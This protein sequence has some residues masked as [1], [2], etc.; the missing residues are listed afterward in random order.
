MLQKSIIR[1]FLILSLLSGIMM[2]IIFPFY[3]NIFIASW[4]S[5]TMMFIFIGGC[6][7]AGIVV[8]LM[9][10][11]IFKYTIFTVL[12]KLSD[13]LKKIAEEDGNLKTRIN[14]QSN[15]EIGALADNFNIFISKIQN[16]VDDVQKTLLTISDFSE[17]L[18][19]T[20]S[21]FSENSISQASSAEEATASAEE[22]LANAEETAKHT[23]EQFDKL[24]LLI[25]RMTELTEIIE[26]AGETVDN[27]L[28]VSQSLATTADQGTGYLEN[29]RSSMEKINYSSE[30]VTSIV[31]IINDISDQINLLSLNAAIEAA[32]AG[33]AGRGFAVVADEISKLADQTS[34]SAKEINILIKDNNDEINRGYETSENT[35][36]VIHQITDGVKNISLMMD[37]IHSNIE[38]EVEINQSFEKDT[39]YVKN[40]SIDIK[41]SSNL[42]K[43][44]FQEIVTAIEMMNRL[45]QKNAEESTELQSKSE[46]LN[47]RIQ[48]LQKKLDFYQV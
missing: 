1:K 14:L 9:S 20:S 22:I 8:G 37:D 4:K 19:D 28:L 17:N 38:K 23:T 40:L 33:D 39:E 15:D 48:N 43:I 10:F 7:V 41:D 2:G 25:Y 18:S 32:R 11:M 29:M 26:M 21:H 30:K 46:F 12:K 45:S 47:E 16:S 42:A 24:S 3:A 27:A 35:I 6:I 34:H 31:A 36:S 5:T 13:E 44:A